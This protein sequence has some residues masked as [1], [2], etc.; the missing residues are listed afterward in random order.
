MHALGATRAHELVENVKR[1]RDYFPSY[2]S[3]DFVEGM[4]KFDGI[5]PRRPTFW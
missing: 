2:F 1:A 3:S 5:F 4:K